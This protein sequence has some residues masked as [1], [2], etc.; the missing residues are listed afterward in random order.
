V[1]RPYLERWLREMRAGVGGQRLS[2]L[3]TWRLDSLWMA[4]CFESRAQEDERMLAD[5]IAHRAPCATVAALVR[6]VER[7][8]ADAHAAAAG[9][10]KPMWQ[11]RDRQWARPKVQGNG[12]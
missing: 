5:A 2:Q 3:S 7:D 9:D 10:L 6:A 1:K 4:A 11:R 8:W 12:H